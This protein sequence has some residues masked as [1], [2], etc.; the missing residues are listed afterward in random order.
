MSWSFAT[1][2]AFEEKLAWMR[3]FVHAEIFPLETLDDIDDRSFRELVR[4]L[5]QQVKDQGLWAAHLP[6]DLGGGGFGQVS[7]ALMHEILGMSVMAPII[8]GNQAP[9]SGNAELIALAGNDSQKERWL[10]PLLAG[11]LK[12][13]FS[14]TEPE[15]AGSD[16]TQL[17]TRA[18]REG[19]GWILDGHKWF[20][21][22]GSAADFL[23]VL[24][25]TGDSAREGASMFIVPTEL[26][27]V[28]IVRDIATMEQPVGW[29]GHFHAGGYGHSEIRYN[30]VHLSDEHLLGETGAGYRLA[31]ARLGPGRLHHCMRWI[32]QSR[33]AFDML[34]ER[35]V[36]RDVHGG[37][38]A[39]KQTVQNW[40]AD[41]AAEIEAA[42]LLTL[43]AAWKVDQEGSAAARIEIS[44]IKYFGAA[45]LY[46]VIDRAL[47]AHGALGYSTDL[48]LEAMYRNARG[49]RIYDGPDEVHRTVVAR[50]ILRGY[51]PRD[52]PTEHVPTR[53]E[54]A[55]ERFAVLLERTAD[56]L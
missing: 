48:P 18:R 55:R 38:L 11:E 32:G 13:G 47:Q 54:A 53:R 39:T 21:S 14:M 3:E 23:I 41:S 45:V 1:D 2:P 25:V 5:Q 44:M 33:R 4:P 52:V 9:D 12:S 29:A 37:A 26:P 10:W 51:V 49:A 36:S 28:E 30:S 16:P 20:T 56:N 15:V 17:L 31:Q 46:N 19:D 8:F 34:C 6:P 24:A 40:I 35:A 43:Q 22:N 27:G 7:L 50:R 42:R